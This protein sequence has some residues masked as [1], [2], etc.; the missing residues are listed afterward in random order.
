MALIILDKTPAGSAPSPATKATNGDREKVVEISH[1]SKAFGSK[2]VLKDIS[3]DLYKG[4]N[5]ITLGK[6]GTGKSVSI[7]CMVGM[8]RQDKGSI[9]VFGDEVSEMNENQLREMR[10]RIG[11]LFQSGP[12]TIP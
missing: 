1:I 2:V 9:K 6:S 4:E 7:Q 5:L 8:L 11:F 10:M 3:Y 12:C